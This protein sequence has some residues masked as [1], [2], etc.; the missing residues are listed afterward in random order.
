MKPQPKL[1]LLAVAAAL[2]LPAYAQFPSLPGQKEKEVQ[3][4]SKSDI[5]K[6]MLFKKG[7]IDACKEEQKK[8]D[9]KVTG[10]LAARFKVNPDGS[11]TEIQILDPKLQ[12]SAFGQCMGNK[13][14]GWKFTK[15]KEKSEAYDLLA[16]F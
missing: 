16:S 4:L 5:G 13:I 11:T 9:P 15:A 14:R 10:N 7:D 2:A 1:A 3:K 12:N 6:E 8:K